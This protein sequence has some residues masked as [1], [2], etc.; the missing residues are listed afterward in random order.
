MTL[1]TSSNHLSSTVSTSVTYGSNPPVVHKLSTSQDFH[2][3]RLMTLTFDPIT[4]K[5]FSAIPIHMVNIG[6]S[7][8]EIL[9]C[10]ET[11]CHVK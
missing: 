11:L 8:I 9:Q 2:V 1:K 7:F 4:L 10:K 6:G 3:R 5:T